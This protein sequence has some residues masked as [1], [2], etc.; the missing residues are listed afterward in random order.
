MCLTLAFKFPGLVRYKSV[1]LLASFDGN[2]GLG[3]LRCQSECPESR[4]TGEKFAPTPVVFT[5]SLKTCGAGARPDPQQVSLCLNNAFKMKTSHWKS[6]FLV[7]E[8]LETRATVSWYLSPQWAGAESQLPLWPN[9]C[10]Q[11]P[12]TPQCTRTHF[13]YRHHLPD[14]CR[15]Q[16]SEPRTFPPSNKWCLSLISQSDRVGTSRTTAHC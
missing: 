4:F 3:R 15:P 16:W 2:W 5:K 6:G 12:T 1:L 11:V 7:S 14:S 9:T 13:V 10:S 8:Q